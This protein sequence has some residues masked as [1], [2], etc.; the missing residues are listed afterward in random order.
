MGSDTS[1][2]V[3]DL[4]GVG[5]AS[6][7]IRLAATARDTTTPTPVTLITDDRGAPEELP[8]WCRMTG[9]LFLGN[10]VGK[11][12]HYELVLHPEKF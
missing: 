7:L 1:P 4:S 11:P 9:H 10:M 6:V 3:L 5:C 8:A 12:D 2:I